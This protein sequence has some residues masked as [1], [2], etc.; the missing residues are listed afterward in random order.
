MYETWETNL[1]GFQLEDSAITNPA[2][3]VSRPS[4]SP[5]AGVSEPGD[6]VQISEADLDF[7][8]QTT[9]LNMSFLRS[10]PNDTFDEALDS[11]LLGG[12]YFAIPQ[13]HPTLF[14]A[15]MML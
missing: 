9:Q 14:D 10:P 13:H 8:Q 1:N 7:V 3:A 5:D 4:S 15:D 12:T 11:S 2:Y 6:A